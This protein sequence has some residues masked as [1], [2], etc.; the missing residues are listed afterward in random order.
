MQCK[1][2]NINSNNEFF[3]L[4]F[5]FIY[6][7]IYFYLFIEVPLYNKTTYCIWKII[8]TEAQIISKHVK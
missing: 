5:L 1:E 8:W 6:L 4:E 2:K 7:F 3:Q